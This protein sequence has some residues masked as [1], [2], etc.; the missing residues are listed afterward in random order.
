MTAIAPQL[1]KFQGFGGLRL[2]VHSGF[3]PKPWTK[4]VE[5]TPGFDFQEKVGDSGSP[6]SRVSAGGT[7]DAASGA[8]LVDS[9]KVF[10]AAGLPKNP[11][12]PKPTDGPT[13]LLSFTLGGQNFV[14]ASDFL[15]AEFSSVVQAIKD[16]VSAGTYYAQ[17]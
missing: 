2:D 17:G 4:T 9:L 10:V 14:T 1:P 12:G 6:R 8:K 16:G 3:A 5:I 7:F 11:P 15:S 13:H